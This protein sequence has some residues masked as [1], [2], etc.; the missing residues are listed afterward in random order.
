MV[1]DKKQKQ[2]LLSSEMVSI[3]GTKFTFLKKIKIKKIKH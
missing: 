1:E 2:K 3:K